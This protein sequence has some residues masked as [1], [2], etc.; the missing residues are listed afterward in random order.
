MAKIYKN[1]YTKSGHYFFNHTGINFQNQHRYIC[2]GFPCF[3]SKFA[4]QA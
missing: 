3:F 4:R 2:V 1:V